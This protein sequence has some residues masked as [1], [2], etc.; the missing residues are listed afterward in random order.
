MGWKNTEMADLTIRLSPFIGEIF[1]QKKLIHPWFLALNNHSKHAS[2]YGWNSSM[3]MEC[4]HEHAMH[5]YVFQCTNLLLFITKTLS[6]WGKMWLLPLYFLINLLSL[7]NK[8]EK[9]N[10]TVNWFL[11]KICKMYDY[12][13]I[14]FHL[15]RVINQ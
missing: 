2:F 14:P 10:Y 5:L 4:F 8:N 3:K 6:L 7:S 12:P 11:T 15:S 1:N 9:K 13:S